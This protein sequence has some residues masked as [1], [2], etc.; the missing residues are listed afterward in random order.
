MEGL[1]GYLAACAQMCPQ[2][3]ALLLRPGEGLSVEPAEP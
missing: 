1:N 3:K 2:V